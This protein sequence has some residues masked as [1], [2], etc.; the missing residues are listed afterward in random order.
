MADELIPICIGCGKHPAEID[1]YS[2]I[3]IRENMTADEFVRREEGT[4]NRKNG[5][6][7]CTLCYYDAGMPSSP[8]GWVAP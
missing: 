3:E 7:L 2:D 5:H 4:Y 8:K 1:E 6:F